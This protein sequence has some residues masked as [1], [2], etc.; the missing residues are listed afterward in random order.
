MIAL[1]ACGSGRAHKIQ[2][3]RNALY[4]ADVEVVFN[5]ARDATIAEFRGVEARPAER[6]IRT[7][8]QVV[9]QRSSERAQ[10]SRVPGA[11][12]LPARQGAERWFIRVDVEIVGTRPFQ[13]RIIGHAAKWV[14]GDA[15]PSP[16]RGADEPSWLGPRTDALRVAIHDRIRRYAV[17]VGGRDDVDAGVGVDASVDVD[18]VTSTDSFAVDARMSD[19]AASDR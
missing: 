11:A 12:G 10:S 14:Q 15:L 13:V 5:A 8:W 9:E 1:L 16:L 6:I 3:A 7:A 18:A 19:D 2:A 4:D 17:P